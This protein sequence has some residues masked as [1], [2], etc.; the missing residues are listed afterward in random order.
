MNIVS[1]PKFKEARAW[2][3]NKKKTTTALEHNIK[4]TRIPPVIRKSSS[5]LTKMGLNKPKVA[6]LTC[7]SLSPQ[8]TPSLFTGG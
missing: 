1:K 4:K 2:K 5:I 3:D 7:L 6:P 8:K